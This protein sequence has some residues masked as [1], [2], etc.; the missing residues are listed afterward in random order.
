MPADKSAGVW[1][2]FPRDDQA[3]SIIQDGRWKFQPN[4][5]DWVIMPHLAK[6]WPSVAARPMA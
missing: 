3:V 4:P 5:V 6:P 1:Q 2:A